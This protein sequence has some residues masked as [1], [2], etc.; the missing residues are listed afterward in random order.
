MPNESSVNGYLDEV[1]AALAALT[2][3]LETESGDEELLDAVCA[4]AVRAIPDADLASVTAIH[5]G[6]PRTAAS[7]DDRTEEIDRA[8]YALGDGPCLEAARSGEI[9][10]LSMPAADQAWPDFAATARKL[11]VGSYL[12]APLHIDETLS[13]AL[14]LFGFGDHG[15][16]DSDSELLKLYTTVVSSSLRAARRYRDTRRLVVQLEE[17]MRTRGVIEQAKGI[18][19]A[20]HKVSADDAF[21]L[22]VTESQHS[23]TKLHEVASHF[24]HSVVSGHENRLGAVES[25]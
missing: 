13:G 17:A 23:N 5:T 11:G 21:R 12:A 19:M 24:V 6:R 25:G 3:T 14:N 20:V 1:N 15:F 2:E 4:Q 16:R 7:T 9:V 18:L 22:L 10:R 8:Q